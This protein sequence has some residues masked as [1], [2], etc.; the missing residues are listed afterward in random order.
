MTTL[1]LHDLVKKDAHS[2]AVPAI[3]KQV[4]SQRKSMPACGISKVGREAREKVFI[5]KEA[6]VTNLL[7]RQSTVFGPKYDIPSTMDVK[8]GRGAGF[9]KGSSTDLYNIRPEDGI[10]TNDE[11][12]I[13]VDSS[14]FKYP[15]DATMK[16]GTEA[17]GRLKDAELIK[18][19]TAAFVG[20]NSPGPVY[21]GRYGPGWVGT[22][23]RMA[24]ARPFGAKL[25][26]KWQELNDLPK[27]VGPGMYPRKDV[28]VGPQYL[29]QRKNQT[30]NA[31]PH[32][33]KFAKTRSADTV[34]YL[35]A[36]K[37]S[38]GKQ[39]LSNNRSEPLVGFGRGTRNQRS[40]TAICITKDDMGPKA[41]MPKPHMS[42]PRLPME[43]EVMKAG[44]V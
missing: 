38:L 43:C 24:P 28:A 13:D 1:D 19:H 33:P 16:I 41:F 30:V 6:A 8:D 39:G 37:S 9:T 27:N 4:E 32:A 5:S 14:Q 29:S 21:G 44:Y 40:R 26:S 34:S 2:F 42:M 17:R 3:G 11:L 36:A 31:F 18:N 10:P 7:C 23:E 20:R 22:K 15:R 12:Q 25:G 35:E